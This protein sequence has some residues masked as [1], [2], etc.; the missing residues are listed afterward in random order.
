MREKD[1]VDL[2]SLNEKKEQLSRRSA[3]ILRECLNKFK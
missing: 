1:L 3:E 2:A